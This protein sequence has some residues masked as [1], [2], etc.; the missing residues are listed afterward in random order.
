MDMSN[1]KREQCKK[2]KR[3]KNKLKAENKIESHKFN[4]LK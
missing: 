3:D 2:D 1:T 4:F